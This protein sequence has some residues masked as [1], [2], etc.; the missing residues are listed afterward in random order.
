MPQLGARSGQFSLGELSVHR[1][2]VCDDA[3]QAS[4]DEPTACSISQPGGRVLLVCRSNAKS[5]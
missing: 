4:G 2:P 5:R 3:M 1:F